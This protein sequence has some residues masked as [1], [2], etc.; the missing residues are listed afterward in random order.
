[1]IKVNIEKAKNIA[2]DI[3]RAARTAEFEPFDNIIAKQLPGMS[4]QQAEAI[5][6]AI[7]EKY[8]Q[9]QTNIDEASDEKALLNIVNSFKST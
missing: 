2:H 9:A 8:A 5:R 7:R 3:R 6:Q 1:M 4:V